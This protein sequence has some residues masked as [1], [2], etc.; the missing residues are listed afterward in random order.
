MLGQARHPLAPIIYVQLGNLEARAGQ[1]QAAVT[2]YEQLLQENEQ[3]PVG[4]QAGL[5]EANYNLG[6][7]QH[8]LGNEQAA[9][10][11]FYRVVD[12]APGH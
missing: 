4:R 7:V 10:R 1:A 3:T 11:A 12:L 8:R 6:L 9:R 5:I 2:W